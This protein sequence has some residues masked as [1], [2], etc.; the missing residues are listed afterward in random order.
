MHTILLP[1]GRKVL[2]EQVV[3][4][5]GGGLSSEPGGWQHQAQ[6]QEVGTMSAAGQGFIR[7]LDQHTARQAEVD[8]ARR[9][10]RSLAPINTPY[11]VWQ[12]HPPDS[13]HSFRVA[14][15]SPCSLLLRNLS[16]NYLYHP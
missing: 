5:S 3:P 13:A 8:E 12:V 1:D 11:L 7:Q 15:P 9:S 16:R 6:L 4:T 14:E 10:V 2:H